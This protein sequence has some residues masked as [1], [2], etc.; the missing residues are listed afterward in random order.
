MQIALAVESDLAGLDFSVLLVDFVADE[1]DGDVIADSDEIFVPLGHVF[2]GDSG[3]DIEHE[4]GG[5]GSN[6]VSFSESS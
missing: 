1:D 3:G 2:V 5:I 4:D 6:V